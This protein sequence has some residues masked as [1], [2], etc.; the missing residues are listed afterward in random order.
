MQM[1]LNEGELRD[2]TKRKRRDRQAAFLDSIGVKYERGFDDSIVVLRDHILEKFK[3][4]PSP[5]QKK[6]NEPNWDAING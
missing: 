4:V 1:F 6:K 2:L 5:T 3:G